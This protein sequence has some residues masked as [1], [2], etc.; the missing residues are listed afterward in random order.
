MRLV[1]STRKGRVTVLRR[2]KMKAE[3]IRKHRDAVKNLGKLMSTNPFTP[4]TK[5]KEALE[6]ITCWVLHEIAAQLAELNFTLSTCSGLRVS[7]TDWCS[8]HQEETLFWRGFHYCPQCY[9]H[10]HKE[11]LSSDQTK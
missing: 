10:I 2:M 6:Y 9:P 1:W 4:A 3:E 7:L 8:D 11:A 5:E